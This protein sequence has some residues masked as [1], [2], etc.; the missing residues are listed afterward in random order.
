MIIPSTDKKTHHHYLNKYISK[1][2]VP[3]KTDTE[4]ILLCSFFYRFIKPKLKFTLHAFTFPPS[5][6]LSFSL[7][8]Y[9]LLQALNTFNKPRNEF[10]VNI[11]KTATRK[12]QPHQKK[13][14]HKHRKKIPSQLL[15]L[16]S[17]V[18][19]NFGT[20]RTNAVH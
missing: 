2:A 1:R 3:I 16:L 8:L 14:Y 13:C 11:N 12:Q 10:L 6:S 17:S 4:L 15:F 7:N 19:C 9:I 5:C 20:D 18:L